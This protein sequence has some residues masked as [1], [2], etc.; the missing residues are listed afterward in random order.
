MRKCAA[1]LAKASPLAGG[2][3]LPNQIIQ[4]WVQESNGERFWAASQEV[5]SQKAR[6]ILVYGVNPI[7]LAS[8]QFCPNRAL[9]LRG[10]GHDKAV[11]IDR[12]TEPVIQQRGHLEPGMNRTDD[13]A[14]LGRKPSHLN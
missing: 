3:H 4:Y 13:T 7:N 9:D 8:K 5:L 1:R 14:R 10:C 12:N 2:A 6:N 11:D